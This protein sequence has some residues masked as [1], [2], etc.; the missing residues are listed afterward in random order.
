MPR[1]APA[2]KQEAV[3]GYGA[4]V[5]LCSHEDRRAEAARVVA[6]TGGTLIHPFEHPDV[7]AG[8]GTAALEMIEEVEDLDVVIAPIGGGGLMSGTALVVR[9]RV[10]GATLIAAEPSA[11][12]DAYRSFRTGVRQPEVEDPD[13][14]ADGLLT[15]VGE[16]AFAILRQGDVRVVLVEDDE[17]AAAARYHLERMKLVVEPSGATALAVLRRIAPEILGARVGLIISGGNTDFSWLAR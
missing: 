10:P 3:A 13:T 17:I 14:I 15:G 5:V 4:R 6:E 7:I 2:V 12:D 16:R 9:D 11:V 1:H 8:Q